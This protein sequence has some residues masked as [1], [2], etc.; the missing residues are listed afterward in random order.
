[1]WS[2]GAVSL[3]TEARPWPARDRPRRAGVSSFGISGTNAHVIVEQY[4]PETV[5]PQGSDVVVPWVLSARSAEA[6]TNQAARLLARVKADPGVRVLDVGW[7]L[8][9]TRSRF[10][11][12]AVIVGADGAQLLRRLA[13]LA[14][15][16]P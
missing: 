15:G 14:G 1:D 3:L 12:R 13:D 6:L 8:V 16:Q 2:A 7:S 4:E 9:S 11:H 10:E 5:A